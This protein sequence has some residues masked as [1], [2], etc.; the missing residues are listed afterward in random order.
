MENVNVVLCAVFAPAKLS[1]VGENTQRA[2]VGTLPQA[3]VT[4][5]EYPPTGVPVIVTVPEAP[6]TIVKVVGEAAKLIE[7]G[8]LIVTVKADETAAANKLS[9]L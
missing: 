7:G 9:P 4:V 5:F 1:D 8:T 2:E 6:C 3:N